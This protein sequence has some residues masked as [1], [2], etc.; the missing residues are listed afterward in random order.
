MRVADTI[1]DPVAVPVAVAVTGSGP[2]PRCWLCC[3]RR[4]GHC[5]P[6]LLCGLCLPGRAIFLPPGVIDVASRLAGVMKM[7]RWGGMHNP[8]SSSV[9]E[10]ALCV[11]EMA[12]PL[13]EAI[14]R[15]DRD[16][17]SQ[18]RRAI[19]SIALNLAE[20][21]GCTGGSARTRFETAR[22]SLNESQA[23]LRVAVAWGYVSSDAARPVLESM[24]CLGGRVYGLVRR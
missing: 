24:H 21:F 12:R 14:Q 13:V 23:G 3:R 10:H 8:Q 20:G 19:S 22:G 17:A 6:E 11:V 5:Y 15:K 7:A 16:L 18:L 9:L 1:A 2:V 4:H